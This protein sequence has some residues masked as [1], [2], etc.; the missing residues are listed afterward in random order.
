MDAWGVAGLIL[1]AIGVPAAIGWIVDKVGDRRKFPRIERTILSSEPTRDWKRESKGGT[2]SAI[3]K[4]D[5]NI[6]FQTD[7]YDEESVQC[8]DF[9]E[10]WANR[11]PSQKAKGYFWD[12]YYG[13]TLLKRFVLVSVDG[14]R[15]MLPLPRSRDDL[16]I[17]PLNNR[18]AQIYDPGESLLAYIIRSGL[19]PPHEPDI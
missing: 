8:D 18:V 2:I 16:R 4:R 17:D 14:G 6:R 7:F 12:L 13:P 11:H 3:Y 9:V 10:P 19:T 1:T 15:A 5:V